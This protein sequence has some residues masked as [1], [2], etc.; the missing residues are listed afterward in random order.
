MDTSKF[1]EIGYWSEIKLDIIREY[2]VAYS[3]ILS[4]QTKPSF[5]HIYID[6]FSG[7]GVN[8][9]RNTGDFVLGSPLNALS[10]EPPFREYHL[11][12]IKK[13]KIE[14]L[15]HLIGDREDVFLYQGDCNKIILEDIIPK[16]GYKDYRRALCILDPYGLHLDWDV[17]Y[18]M[19]KE[20]SIE[21]F[22]NFPVADMNRNVLWRDATN[23]SESQIER[24]NKFWGDT[25][26]ENVAY[27]DSKQKHLFGNEIKEKTSNET[28]ANAYR[29]RLKE[30]AGFKYVPMPIAMKNSQN[31]I[32]YYFFFASPKPVAE[33]IV[34][35]IFN[36]YEDRMT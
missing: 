21:I 27:V 16:V 13:E 12:D 23:V 2:A 3:K 32:I 30:V 1:D 11:I 15:D 28:I 5:Y 29:H 19:G 31:A 33:N 14:S 10:V 35:S 9:S 8:I 6:T 36:K 20:K 24:M 34:K 7:A 4:A 22:L 26:W 18:N 17:V 25:S